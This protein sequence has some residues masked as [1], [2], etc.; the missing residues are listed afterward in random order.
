LGL[1]EDFAEEL[2]T[3][4]VEPLELLLHGQDIL[5]TVFMLGISVGAVLENRAASA[6][7]IE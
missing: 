4:H 5:R 2:G 7:I 3:L 6:P 1:L